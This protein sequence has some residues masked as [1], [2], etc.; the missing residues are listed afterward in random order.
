M[1]TKNFRPK[2]DHCGKF[3]SFQ[4]L[5]ESSTKYHIQELRDLISGLKEELANE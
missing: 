4:D 1:L 5:D 3:I 2:C